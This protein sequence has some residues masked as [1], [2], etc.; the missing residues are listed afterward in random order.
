MFFTEGGRTSS[1]IA[2]PE[3]RAIAKSARALCDDLLPHLMREERVLFPWIEAA[4]AARDRGA[5]PPPAQFGTVKNPIRVMDHDHDVVKSLLGELRAL[6]DEHRA[7]AWASDPTR[8]LFRTLAAL[9]RDLIEH[10]HWENDVL[11]VRAVAL[12]A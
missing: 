4:E 2:H 12:E 8:E 9:D 1:A 10:I 3:L 5:A 11:F 7:P 6:T